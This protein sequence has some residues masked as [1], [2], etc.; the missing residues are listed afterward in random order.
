MTAHTEYNQKYKERFFRK[1]NKILVAWPMCWYATFAMWVVAS[2]TVMDQKQKL[3]EGWVES[4]RVVM[5]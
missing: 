5:T 2:I 3:L 4:W 1:V